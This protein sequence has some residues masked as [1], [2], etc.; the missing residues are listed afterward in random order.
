MAKCF[1]LRICLILTNKQILVP[2]LSKNLTKRTLLNK[3]RSLISSENSNVVYVA[4]GC[5]KSIL[6]DVTF[7]Q[8]ASHSTMASTLDVLLITANASEIKHVPSFV[9]ILCQDLRK[10]LECRKKERKKDEQIRP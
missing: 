3:S 1:I 7:S 5:L 8:S 9:R 2:T 10:D 4:E 6:P